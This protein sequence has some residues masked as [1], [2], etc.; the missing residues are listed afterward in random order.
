[1]IPIFPPVQQKISDH[2]IVSA[3]CRQ[4]HSGY[5][6]DDILKK[7]MTR[8]FLITLLYRLNVTDV[9]LNELIQGLIPIR[10]IS[11]DGYGFVANVECFVGMTRGRVMLKNRYL[12]KKRQISSDDVKA[13][14]VL[15]SLN[16][17]YGHLSS[18][19]SHC[20]S[21]EKNF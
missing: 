15:C 5:D 16:S 14:W 13:N 8:R 10:S 7:F 21:F 19:D 2:I 9:M 12:K 1:M 4:K 6:Y 3:E 18:V 11:M 17:S 20:C